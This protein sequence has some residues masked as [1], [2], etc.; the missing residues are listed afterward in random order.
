MLLDLTYALEVRRS[1]SSNSRTQEVDTACF[2]KNKAVKKLEYE[3]DDIPKL[4]IKQ[5]Y[6]PS[7]GDV[8]YIGPGCNIPRIKLRDLL[9]NNH[10]KTTNDVT[11]ATHIFVDTTFQKMVKSTWLHTINKKQLIQFVELLTTE[12]YLEPNEVEDVKDVIKDLPDDEQINVENIVKYHI[13]NRSC[14]LFNG[15]NKVI[16]NPNSRSSYMNYV[17]SEH[18]DNWQ[19]I[20]SNLDKVY[21]Y[22][23][24]ISHINAEDSITI[25]EKV[26]EQLS[27]MFNSEDAD[28][29][30]LAME[31]MANSNYVDSLLYLELL[32]VDHGHTM[33]HC[34]TKRHVNFKSLADYLCK[35]L[36]YLGSS[37]SHSVIDSLI[38]KNAITLDSVK[39]ILNRYSTDFY[40]STEHFEVKQV[41]L[42]DKL[43]KILNVNYIKTV[44]EDYVPE[45]VEEQVEKEKEVK[46]EEFSWVE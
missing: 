26:F 21:D 45:V 41:T 4:P 31:I 15:V 29:H 22:K 28:N 10:A 2:Y 17:D 16:T 37:N 38:E 11:K 6:S 5:K 23:C 12:D 43:A 40:H 9:L 32:F 27:S 20:M 33:N 39:Y 3:P 14:S 25:T 18:E 8:L 46:P 24:L 42:S 44:K 7:P 36:N 35:N 19:Y 30:I 1:Y 13:E 34:K